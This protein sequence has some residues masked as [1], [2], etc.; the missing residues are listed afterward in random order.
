[1]RRK[2]ISKII[3]GTMISTTLCTLVPIKASAEWVKDYQNNWYYTQDNQKMTGWKRIDGQLYYFDDNGKMQTGWIKAGSSW[4]FLQNNGALK[5]GWINYNKNLYYA[6]SSGAMQTGTINVAGK[7]YMLGDNGI[8]KTSNT[9]IDGQF[10]TIGSNGEVVGM[11]VPTPDKE[12]DD[13]GNV[14]TVLKNTDNNS[15]TSPTDSKFNEVIKDQ[16]VSNDDPNQGRTFKVRFKD[17]NGAELLTKSVKN[18]KSVD[19][20]EPAKTGYVFASWNTKSD[21]SG[22]SYDE[23]DDIK[24]KEDINLYAQWTDDTA[25][26]VDGITIKGNSYVTVNSTSQM[27]AEVSPSDASNTSVTWSVT[28]GTGKATIDSN[29][30]LTGTTNGTVTVKATSKD[31]SNISGMKEVTVSATEVVIPVSQISV[32]SN[33]GVST[34]TANGGTLQMKASVLPTDANKQDVTWSIEDRTGSA[35]IDSTTGLVTAKSNGT[36]TVKATVTNKDGS[37]VVGSTTITISGQ[38]LKIPVDSIVVAGKDGAK[39][40]DTDA[41]LGGTSGTLQMNATVLPT[42]ATNK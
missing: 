31:G 40:I 29:G 3:L 16:S 6:D 26:Y 9:V 35:S 14:L 20:Y 32:T 36:V 41:A 38:L 28:N 17:S 2:F 18:G 4:Y 42:T 15:T 12:F 25:I 7:V 24:V 39:T 22:K 21:G 11:K 37:T 13:S 5:T 33:T 30:L 19:L 23:N 1:M 10:Y 34:I 27:T 8:A